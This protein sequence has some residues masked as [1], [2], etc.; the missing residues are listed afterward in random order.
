MEKAR[1]NTELYSNLRAPLNNVKPSNFWGSHQTGRP[2][3]YYTAMYMSPGIS[4]TVAGIYPYSSLK[5]AVSEDDGFKMM[6]SSLKRAVSEDDGFKMMYSSLKRGIF[7]DEEVLGERLFLL[8]RHQVEVC[9][10][11]E[12]HEVNQGDQSVGTEGSDCEGHCQCI[13]E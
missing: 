2:L 10:R 4:Q 9:Q 13:Q 12:D 1:C 3:F 6:Y 11:N 8:W 5:R 7:K